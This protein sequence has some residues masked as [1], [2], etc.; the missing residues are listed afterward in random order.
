MVSHP[1]TSKDAFSA[2]VVKSSS[3]SGKTLTNIKLGRSPNSTTNHFGG[4]LAEL[5]IFSRELNSTEEQKIEG[6]L[7]HHWGAT[8]SLN[9]DHTYKSIAP[10]FDN[11][12]L[13]RN[14]FSNTQNK[15]DKISSIVSWFD[16]SDLN[17][18]GTTDSTAS[19]NI[20][21]WSD[22]SGKGHH[23]TSANGTPYMNATGGPSSGRAVEIRSGDYLPVSGTLFAKD[24][25]VV[26]RSP[27]ANTTWSYYGGPFG[28]NGAS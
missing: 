6:Y 3:A 22:K 23:A 27:A 14:Q 20:S 4:D 19:G 26:L 9:V 7:G 1:S 12:P 11:K 16:A 28:W 21:S 24:H 15:P 17:A 2:K 5:L 13:I 25:F 10:I 8:D 18:D